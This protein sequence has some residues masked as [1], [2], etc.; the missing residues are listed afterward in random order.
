MSRLTEFYR[1]AGTDSRGRTLAEMWAFSDGE[2]EDIHDFIQWMFPLREPSRFN[3]DAPLPTAA[4]IAE[5][6][7]DPALQENLLRSFG[8]FLAFLGLRYEGGRVEKAPDF[9][10]KQDVWLD[11]NHNWLRITRVLACTRMLGL[12]GASR[13]FF[14][15]LA[16]Y[17]HGGHSGITDDTFRYWEAAAIGIQPA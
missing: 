10:Q 3:P 9:G 2:M 1:G 13:A 4:D 11:P 6:R 5:F 14:D 7:T 15:F 16:A 8:A 17:R 12:E